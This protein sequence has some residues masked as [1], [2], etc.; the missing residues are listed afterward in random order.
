MNDQQLPSFL[1]PFAR[2]VLD[3]IEAAFRRRDI[4][5][6]Y[7]PGTSIRGGVLEVKEVDGAPDVTGVSL[8]IVSNGKLTDNGGGSVSL[9][10][11]GGG[12][13]H[14]VEDE[15]TPLTQRSKFNF[16]GAGVTATDNPGADATDVTI[17]ANAGPTGATGPSGPTGPAGPTGPSGP[18][19]PN[20]ADAQVGP[21]APPAPATG[22]M[23]LD[24]SV[25][26]IAV[27]VLTLLVMGDTS[28][29]LTTGG[30]KNPIILELPCATTITEIRLAVKTMPT[31]AAIIVDVNLAGMT[32]F[33]NQAHRPQIAAGTDNGTS[34]NIDAASGTKGQRV[35]FDTDQVGSTV[36]G[37]ILTV[38]VI[39]TRTG[40]S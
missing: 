30:D 8:I 5:S 38:E 37:G 28:T 14:T 29:T 21:T 23:W 34:T 9:D 3:Q 22:E 4:G 1:R 15:G 26:A 19:G 40:S 31:G 16:I 12:G 7:I 27:S 33:T 24:T 11:S 35:T 20:Y 36:A 17:P 18:T 10:I 32:I 2:W 25:P 39:G 6:R 13:G